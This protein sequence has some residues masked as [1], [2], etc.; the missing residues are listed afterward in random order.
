MRGISR[1]PI[2]YVPEIDRGLPPEERTVFYLLPIKVVQYVETL[3]KY[4]NALQRSAIT[5]TDRIDAD[6]WKGASKE[7]FLNIVHHVENYMFSDDIE[8]VPHD[9]FININ[10]DDVMLKE[11]LFY[12]LPAGVV[13]ELIEV[14]NNPSIAMRDKKKSN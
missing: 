11:K 2:P 7:E 5:G 8:G 10:P 13:K 14:A 1:K 9:E 12:D 6:R 3:E 4:N